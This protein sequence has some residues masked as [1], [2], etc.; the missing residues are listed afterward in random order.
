[1]PLP[2]SFQSEAEGR[3]PFKLPKMHKRKPP[4]GTRLTNDLGTVMQMNE[5]T[6]NDKA[7]LWSNYERAMVRPVLIVSE[8]KGL[9]G[10]KQHTVSLL[11]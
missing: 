2:T 1:M 4:P 10:D 11:L 5:L 9:Y 6:A 8:T 3:P 7:V